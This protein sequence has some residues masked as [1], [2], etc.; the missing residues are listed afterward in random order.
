[1]YMLKPLTVI[2]II[3]YASCSMSF[4]KTE[5]D[6]PGITERYDTVSYLRLGK[7]DG[8]KIFVE[9]DVNLN[10]G[11]CVL[12][13]DMSLC[14]K[15]GI[16]SNGTL[17]GDK[18]KILGSG[19]IFNKVTIKGDWNVPNI[20]TRLFANLDEVNSLRQV[21]ALA[22][23]NVQNTITIDKGVY[24]VKVE[25]DADACIPLCSNIDFIL[26]GTIL[27]EPNNY[28]TYYILN[29]K[30]ENIR[31]RGKGTIIG[32]KFSHTGEKGE[33][34]MGINFK[35]ATN[36]SVRGLTIQK[37]WGDCIYVGGNSKNILIEKCTLDH[38]RRQGISV[39]KAD[40][41]TISD[42]KITNVGGKMPQYAIDIEPNLSDSV[43]R[44]LIENVIVKDCMGGFYVT[45]VSRKEKASVPWIGSVIIRKCKV[46]S[47]R[48]K[49]IIINRC[50]SVKIEKCAIYSPKGVTA[51]TIMNTRQA[52]IY[53]NSISLNHDIAESV[54][55]I[56]RRIAK[57]TTSKDKSS[58]IDISNTERCI[59]MNNI[60]LD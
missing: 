39:T 25:K 49:P 35:G 8:K 3:L 27:L 15:G 52:E 23:A 55:R 19:A 28:K 44:I 20:S 7:N 32:D 4:P 60:F 2:F 17:I 22:H 58:I 13:K 53:K 41:V 6:I 54:R 26:N 48:L 33:W 34:G 59:E 5:V 11:I 36:S 46:H 14:Q 24:R 47:K 31:V 9:R 1:M 45:R 30:G 57:K 43:N 40:N 10:G 56:A 38:G 12:P 51:I 29:V 16:I 42:C 21:V 37:C 50:D 18:T